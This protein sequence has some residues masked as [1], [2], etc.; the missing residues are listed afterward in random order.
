M[1]FQ[2][3]CYLFENERKAHWHAAW[4][5]CAAQDARLVKIESETENDFITAEL[6]RLNPGSSD[7][8]FTAGNDLD[9]ENEWVWADMINGTIAITNVEDIAYSNWGETEPNDYKGNEDCLS[10]YPLM[11]YKW[12]DSPCEL[13]YHFICEKTNE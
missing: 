11:D 5:E 9:I 6:Q 2:E 12:N 4:D 3:S 1:T 13:L 8:Y 10:I 7:Q